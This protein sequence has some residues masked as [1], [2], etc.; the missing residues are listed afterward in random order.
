MI[1]SILLLFSLLVLASGT[2]ILPATNN[3]QE[4]GLSCNI[5][6]Y[7]QVEAV[8]KYCTN[9]ILSN[10]EVPSG[11]SLNLHLRDGSTL[12][13]RGSLFHGHGEKYWD[14]HGGSGGVTKPKLLQIANVN[15]G[16]F[17]NVHLKNCPLFFT[18]ITKV[19]DLT[20]DGWNADCSEGDKILYNKVYTFKWT[21]AIMAI[22]IVTQLL[23]DSN[24]HTL[25][26]P[27]QETQLDHILHCMW[28]QVFRLDLQ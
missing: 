2:S 13:V 24:C 4:V 10:V 12:T 6:A 1:S 26:E 25:L 21:T 7:S 27:F 20:L 8:L 11:K 9:I 19:K 18:G 22:P 16:H 23:K 3:T 5:K 28:E 17:S 15:N 14:G